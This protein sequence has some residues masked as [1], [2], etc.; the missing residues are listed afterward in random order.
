MR[1]DALRQAKAKVRLP[2][3]SCT[4]DCLDNLDCHKITSSLS[5]DF[6][7]SLSPPLGH[8]C[9]GHCVQGGCSMCRRLS[10]S[11]TQRCRHDDNLF[12]CKWWLHVHGLVCTSLRS[13]SII[14]FSSHAVCRDYCL[15]LVNESVSTKLALY[16]I[17]ACDAASGSRCRRINKLPLS[18]R[19]IRNSSSKK[20]VS[21]LPLALSGAVTR[22]RPPT[23]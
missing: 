20:V 12:N 8:L 11:D 17:L 3:A 2:H 22:I 6:T 21:S 7:E 14:C 18:P 15:R 4:S 9:C 13:Q 16:H 10:R 1:M 19:L 5:A 23:A